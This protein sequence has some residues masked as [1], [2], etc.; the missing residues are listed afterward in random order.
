MTTIVEHWKSG[1]MWLG[2]NLMGMLGLWGAGCLVFFYL[3]N[4]PW[5]ELVDRGQFFL[6]SVGVLGQA[7]YILTKEKKITTLPLRSLFTFLSVAVLLM[8]TLFFAGTMLSNFTDIIIVESKMWYLRSLGLVTFVASM[9][10]G[11]FVTIAAE[12]RQE[13]DMDD[14]NQQSIRRLG[15]RISNVE[16]KLP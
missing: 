16:D 1:A 2:W 4:A 13:V 3:D 9:L 14:L 12:D 5:F 6:Y 8:C 11:F 10:I 15:D 7:M